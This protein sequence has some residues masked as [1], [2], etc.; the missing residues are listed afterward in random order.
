MDFGN[1]TEA[2]KHV[3]NDEQDIDFTS[4]AKERDFE[5]ANGN[6]SLYVICTNHFHLMIVVF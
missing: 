1:G 4:A 5:D 2:S 6:T 3:D